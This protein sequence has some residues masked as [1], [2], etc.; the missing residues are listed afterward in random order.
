ME[1]PNAKKPYNELKKQLELLGRLEEANAFE[2]LIRRKFPHEINSTAADTQ[3][4]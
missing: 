1:N 2:Y 4:Q 3:Q